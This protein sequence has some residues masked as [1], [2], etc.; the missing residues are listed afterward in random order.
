MNYYFP[1]LIETVTFPRHLTE[2]IRYGTDSGESACRLLLRSFCLPK[3]ALVELPLFVCDSLKMAV[4]K[5][6]FKPIYLDLLDAPSFHTDYNEKIITCGNA[7]AV[8]LV[9]LYGFLHPQTRMVI[10]FCKRG[11]ICLIHDIAQSCGIDESLLDYGSIFYSFG[12]GKSTTAAG[13]G[14][15][16]FIDNTTYTKNVK[17]APAFSNMKAY[18]FMKQRI[19]GE[20]LSVMEKIES[21]II[22]KINKH[23]EI[24]AMT[25]LQK[26]A[27][28]HVMKLLP[29]KASERQ[30]RHDLFV[31]AI[32]THPLLMSIDGGAQ[33]QYFKFIMYVESEHIN[34]FKDYLTQNKIPFHNLF[35][36]ITIEPENSDSFKNFKKYAP[37]IMEI[38]SEASIP[39]NEI[40]RVAR[41]LKDFR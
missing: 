21:R 20:S 32:A 22:Q 9:H 36:N 7:A 31:Q 33:G 4:I 24:Y 23:T 27:A 34:R 13:G 14:M 38:S 15:I 3:G 28:M 8:I 29:A 17:K 16:K 35:D 37:G 19:Y 26:K 1:G 5:E 10:E 18:H 40:K 39:L 11:K 30:M 25:S 12:P 6:G 41:L 2:S